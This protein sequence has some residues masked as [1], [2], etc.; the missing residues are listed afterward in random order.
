MKIEIESSAMPQQG[1]QL[2]MVA[3]VRPDGSHQTVTTIVDDSEARFPGV[4]TSAE[5]TAQ[6]NA[7]IESAVR[8]ALHALL[9]DS[10]GRSP[11]TSVVDRIADELRKR[12]I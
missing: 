12:G 7:L 10:F 2:F 4:S 8:P 9:D 5:R 6:V 3:L 1:K 11:V